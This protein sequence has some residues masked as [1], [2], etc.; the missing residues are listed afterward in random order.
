VQ[1]FG[2]LALMVFFPTFLEIP[3]SAA[4]LFELIV[5]FSSSSA[6]GVFNPGCSLGTPCLHRRLLLHPTQAD[7]EESQLCPKYSLLFFQLCQLA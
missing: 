5:F 1:P 7:P 4:C 2:K 3:L 6:S